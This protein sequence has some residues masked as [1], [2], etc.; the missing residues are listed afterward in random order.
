M[1]L[2][3][4]A[5]AIPNVDPSLLDSLRLL[6]PAVKTAG[7]HF[8][9]VAGLSGQ[10]WRVET[11]AGCFLARRQSAAMQR[12]GVSR[13]REQRMLRAQAAGETGPQPLGYH[14]GWLWLR[15]LPG[16]PLEA[17]AFAAGLEP[18]AALLARVHRQPRGGTPLALKA[19]LVR[20]WQQIDRRRLTPRWLR[21]HRALMRAPLPP[22]LKCA[23]LHMDIHAS[24][25]I[26]TP[27]GWRLIDWEYAADGDI[28]CELAALVRGNGWPETCLPALVDAYCAQ[29]GYGDAR[30][31]A[32]AIGRWLPWIDYLMLMWYEVRWQQSGEAPF[33][34]AADA[35]HAHLLNR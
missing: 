2:S 22:T 27:S 33:R 31:L 15:W 3:G 29:G 16:A 34:A 10:S 14:L 20:Q 25:L 1:K 8:S 32:A 6:L 23:P 9:P 7:C 24:N 26:A 28:A 30:R 19:Q 35:L 12:M 5:V 17:S 13:R 11:S 18:L 4:Q 21:W